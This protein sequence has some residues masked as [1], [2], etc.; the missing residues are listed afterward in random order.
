MGYKNLPLASWFFDELNKK[1][2]RKIY[3]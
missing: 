3:K 2:S 1:N